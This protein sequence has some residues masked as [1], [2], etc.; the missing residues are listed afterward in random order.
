MGT[1]PSRVSREAGRSRPPQASSQALD[2]H[3]PQVTDPH[4][5]PLEVGAEQEGGAHS[6]VTKERR[7]KESPSQRPPG[8][9]GSQPA[10]TGG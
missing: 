9:E 1:K 10:G 7:A 3:C 5:S 8:M 6:S 2:S 4:H